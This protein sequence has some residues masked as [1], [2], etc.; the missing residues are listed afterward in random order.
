MLAHRLSRVVG[1]SE[2]NFDKI[3]YSLFSRNSVPFS[4]G[5]KSARSFDYI[6]RSTHGRPRD[7]IRYL[8]VCAEMQLERGGGQIEIDLTKYMV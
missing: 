2:N 6:S 1:V 3:W 5:R 8:Q 4:T 7:Y